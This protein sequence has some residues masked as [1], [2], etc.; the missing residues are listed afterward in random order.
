ML[1][2]FESHR[3]QGQSQAEAQERDIVEW[4]TGESR[5]DGGQTRDNGCTYF[6]TSVHGASTHFP[7]SENSPVISEESQMAGRAVGPLPSLQVTL[8]VPGCLSVCTAFSCTCPLP[9]LSL[10][11]FHPR[12]ISTREQEA[13]P[14]PASL[15]QIKRFQVGCLSHYGI[16]DTTTSGFTPLSLSLLAT[17]SACLP[18][19]YPGVYSTGLEQPW[20]CRGPH[21]TISI[22]F[23]WRPFCQHIYN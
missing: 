18:G 12:S 1:D 21:V 17:Q 15:S 4:K 13:K 14:G 10:W 7:L 20:C 22:P 5:Q 6:E 16:A 19:V 9:W 3:S 11:L 23:F 2:M 8:S